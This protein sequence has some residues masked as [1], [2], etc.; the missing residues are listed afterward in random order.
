MGNLFQVHK[1][2]YFNKNAVTKMVKYL[3]QKSLKEQPLQCQTTAGTGLEFDQE[4]F[5]QIMYVK[6]SYDQKTVSYY[7]WFLLFLLFVKL[8]FWRW[9]LGASL[10]DS[11]FPQK[12]Q[13]HLLH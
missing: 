13:S 7:G 4:N 3:V 6:I 10:L 8:A 9:R 2:T 12:N 5:F 11:T 1:L